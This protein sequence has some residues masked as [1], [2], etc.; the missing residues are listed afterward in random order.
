VLL[1]SAEVFTD[2]W[3]QPRCGPAAFRAV[4]DWYS[5]Q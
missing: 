4:L 3:V 2:D 5:E 1:E